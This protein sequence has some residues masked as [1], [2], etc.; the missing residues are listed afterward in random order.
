MVQELE[1]TILHIKL[2]FLKILIQLNLKSASEL[3]IYGSDGRD[4]VFLIKKKNKKIFEKIWV[5]F[6]ISLVFLFRSPSLLPISSKK[7]TPLILFRSL[8]TKKVL[9]MLSTEILIVQ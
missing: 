3:N 5:S 9:I 1:I 2:F 8:N 7:F 4:G 6:N